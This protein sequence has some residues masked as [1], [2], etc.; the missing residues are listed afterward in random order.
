MTRLFLLL[1]VAFAFAAQTLTIHAY[2]AE[3]VHFN[4]AVQPAISKDGDKASATGLSIWGH[5]SRPPG[6]GPFPAMVL[7]HGCAGI[8]PTHYRWSELLNEQGYVTLIPDSFSP[9]SVMNRCTQDAG[10]D[11]H[12]DRSLDAMGALAYLQSRADINVERIGIM[13]WSHGATMALETVSRRGLASRKNPAFELAITMFP[14]CV[15]DRRFDLPVLIL[16]GEADDWSPAAYCRD[17]AAQNEPSGMVTLITYARVF[18]AFD[19]MEVA[20][21]FAAYGPNQMQYWVKYDP[22]AHQDAIVRVRTFLT[23]H[24]R[25]P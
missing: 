23:E 18:H 4:S 22:R 2:G 5:L 8:Q 21:G 11:M 17:L 15:A 9:R 19:L 16:I 14:Y 25:A 6:E 24:M 20:D 13:G 3:V 10:P 1:G 7:L 12:Q